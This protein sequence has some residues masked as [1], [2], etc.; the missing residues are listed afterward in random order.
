ML[1][2]GHI[3][4]SNCLP[5][6]AG[7]LTGTVPF[8][9]E[10]V[11]GI[12]SELNLLLYK[13]EIDVSPSSSIEY[14]VNPGR[15]LIL[16]GFSITSRKEVGSIILQSRVPITGL[17]GRTVSLTTASATS[18]VL[19]RIL[20]KL[21]YGVHPEYSTFV[22]G[23]DDPFGRVDAML[24]IGDLALMARPRADYPYLYDLGLLWHEFTG[25]PFVFAMWQVNR[26]KKIDNDL[27]R[28]YDILVRSKAYGL[29][30]IPDLAARYADRFGL[31]V[32]T[33]AGYWK[34]LSY[35]LGDDE[36]RGLLSF[37]RYA[38]EIGEIENTTELRFWER[39]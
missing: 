21:R 30:N 29:A 26:K 15:Y 37:Y 10:L 1:K 20:L 18:V 3:I 2:L 38:A 16:P 39:K 8:P 12:P 28:L 13:G 25:L 11:E 24:F 4:Y 36:K 14:A 7:I 33:L 22:Q 32:Q 17:D 31:P 34:S 6:H 9:F 23:K 27:S 35:D 19:L 5:P